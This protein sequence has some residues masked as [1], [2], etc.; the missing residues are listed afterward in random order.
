MSKQRLEP[1]TERTI[2][3][4]LTSMV[5]RINGGRRTHGISG[6]FRYDRP[7]DN[8]TSCGRAGITTTEHYASGRP[9]RI[10]CRSCRRARARAHH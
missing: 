9:V 2:M 8:R 3:P 6:E 5:A 7:A 10:T 4:A 1:D